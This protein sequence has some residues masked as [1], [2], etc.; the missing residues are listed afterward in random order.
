MKNFLIGLA[1]ANMQALG[2]ELRT[3]DANTTG[4]DDGVGILLTVTAPV[5]QTFAAGGGESKVRA[6]LKAAA[7]AIYTFLD[8]NPPQ[9]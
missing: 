8:T 7:D 1:I 3:R 4:A 5:L 6:A 2:F 9:Q